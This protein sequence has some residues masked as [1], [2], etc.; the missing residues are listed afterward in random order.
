MTYTS[1]TGEDEPPLLLNREGAPAGTCHCAATVPGPGADCG[2]VSVT[3]SCFFN[4][5]GTGASGKQHSLLYASAARSAACR[6]AARA[7]A[8]SEPG[9]NSPSAGSLAMRRAKEVMTM[10]ASGASPPF[11]LSCGRPASR[12]ASAASRAHAAAAS[13]AW[14][15]HA[16]HKWGLTDIARH[17]IGI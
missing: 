11:S 2:G 8:A 1:T 5:T 10:R 16:G 7:K 17:V 12:A 6:A 4:M 13:A 14:R 3:L 9:A 15:A